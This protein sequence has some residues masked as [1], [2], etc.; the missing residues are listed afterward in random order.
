MKNLA[1]IIV[2]LVGTSLVTVAQ[3]GTKK[4]TEPTKVEVKK[5]PMNTTPVKKDVKKEVPT[6]KLKK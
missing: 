4:Q 1:L 5:R 3:D 6:K 2:V